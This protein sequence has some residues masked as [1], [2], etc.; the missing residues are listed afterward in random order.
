MEKNSLSEIVNKRF[1]K[2]SIVLFIVFITISIGAFYIFHFFIYEREVK[3]V[4]NDIN[5]YFADLNNKIHYLEES[6]Q[7]TSEK[8]LEKVYSIS[9][10]DN[11]LDLNSIHNDM[12]EAFFQRE[13]VGPDLDK[14]HYYI[15]NQDGVIT[16]TSYKND[17]GLDLSRF[18]DFWNR[19]TGLS[20][21]QMLLDSIDDEVRTG[22]LRLYSYIKLPD[23]RIFEIGLSFKK[24]EEYIVNSLN[25]MVTNTNTDIVVLSPDFT[26]FFG[27][28]TEVTDRDIELLEESIQSNQ[29]VKRST[30]FFQNTYYR[31]WQM[32]DSDYTRRY[33]KI[34]VNHQSL[35][36]L[37]YALVIFFFL[38]LLFIYFFRKDL[39]KLMQDISKP[40]I[41]LSRTMSEFDSDQLAEEKELNLPESNIKE[42]KRINESYLDMVQEVRASYEQLA[43][44]NEELMAMNDELESSY[45]E[46]EEQNNRFNQLIHLITFNNH[47]TKDNKKFLSNLLSTAVEIIPEANYGSVYTYGNNKVNYIDS[48]GFDLNKLKD[49]NISADD[50]HSSTKPV[51]VVK[52][53]K[54]INKNIDNVENNE[55]LLATLEDIKETLYCDLSVK[56]E[57]KAGIS[58][59]IAAS[60]EKEFDDNSIKIFKAFQN[61]ATSFFELKEYNKL[62]GQFTKELIG[63]IIRLLEMHDQYTRGHS[64]NVAETAAN[65][66]EHMG[67][68]KDEITDTY[69]AGMV[70]DL[71][72]LI[73]PLKILNKEGTLSENEY[74][75]VKN[76]PYWGYKALND[77]ESLKPIGKYVLYHHEH[78]DG[79][80]YPEG[81]KED[82]IPIISQILSVADAWDAM[83]SN[84]SYRAPLSKE[85]AFEELQK[86]KGSQFSPK[87]VEV[88]M[89]M[90][91]EEIK[92]N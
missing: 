76:H 50:F 12:K 58:V 77:S 40:V 13:T 75:L 37:L 74:D 92:G 26:P 91:E 85:V 11:S 89:K 68:S 90:K 19:L 38:N 28:D 51:E 42:I 84:R 46:L 57:K 41:K 54:N 72:K 62:Q 64:E 5:H 1:I 43:A 59:D 34:A 27:N 83:T 71:G 33:V 4:E 48:V 61:I 10:N 6:Y 47:Q 66:A 53:F 30:S 18:P 86:N 23:N 20:Q 14:V 80:G 69:W 36:F 82:E 73:I 81:L 65:I 21:G 79:K 35:K 63:A 44:Y 8:Q 29:V 3:D 49:L 87:V 7:L 88:F 25:D 55:Y 17:M 24:I 32:G 60:S 16:K 39:K 22:Q 9:Q 31:G 70:H 15:I 67:L 45:L 56:G 2:F 78:W 52:N